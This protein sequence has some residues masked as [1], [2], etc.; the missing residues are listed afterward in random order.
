MEVEAVGKIK[1]GARGGGSEKKWRKGMEGG[2][3]IVIS[4]AYH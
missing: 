1:S 2:F 3:I 4:E